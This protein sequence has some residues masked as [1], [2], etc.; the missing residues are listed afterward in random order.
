MMYWW[1]SKTPAVGEEVAASEAQQRRLA[2]LEVA[3]LLL[4]V[5]GCAGHRRIGEEFE[6]LFDPEAIA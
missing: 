2:E 4:H 3:E 1:F 6:F 5:D